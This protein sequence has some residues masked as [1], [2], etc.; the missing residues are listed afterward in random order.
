MGIGRSKQQTRDDF[1][2]H[3]QEFNCR[4][5]EALI[6]CHQSKKT[7]ITLSDVWLD[8]REEALT[9][10]RTV[11]DEMDR[12]HCNVNLASLTGIS[13]SIAG[14]TAGIGGLLMAPFS[15]GLSLAMSAGGIVGTVAGSATTLSASIAEVY[16][17]K[18]LTELVS[19]TLET[20]AFYTTA[21][22]AAFK[23]V[24]VHDPEVL[25]I[26]SELKD[27]SLLEDLDKVLKSS[28]CCD[29]IKKRFSGLKSGVNSLQDILVLVKN[30]YPEDSEFLGQLSKTDNLFG[31]APTMS[32]T[33]SS[34]SKFFQ[35]MKDL[36]AV[37]PET[38][39]SISEAATQTTAASNAQVASLASQMITVGL[40]AVFVAIDVYNFM[41]TSENYEQGSKTE[42]AMKIR[43]VAENLAKERQQIAKLNEFYRQQIHVDL[44]KDSS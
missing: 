29:Q 36:A 15:G 26:L 19:K 7:F 28:P 25:K 13:S 23:E 21:L 22:S 1:K 24:F 3:I 12:H 35:A 5:H 9:T 16:L 30:L 8:T 18:E 41:K 2:P 38:L 11:A 20:D 14:G 6:G 17:S 33:L 34:S 43:C 40:G 4:L 10:L 44:F 42:I 31:S 37:G 27:E 32:S 39:K